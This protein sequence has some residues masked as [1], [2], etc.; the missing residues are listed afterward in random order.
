VLT[1]IESR[2]RD[3]RPSA[4]AG[5]LADNYAAIL[6][7]I[8]TNSSEELRRYDTITRRCLQYVDVLSMDTRVLLGAM[9]REN[10]EAQ[11][12]FVLEC[13]TQD[14]KLSERAE[15][16]LFV[17]KDRDFDSHEIRAELN[18]LSCHCVWDFQ[19]A[20]G[21]IEAELKSQS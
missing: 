2:A 5:R 7:T 15:V 8:L 18:G 6:D 10:L 4:Y 3:A 16:K 14:A 12:A 1:A 21:R 13:I 9:D 20:L 11:D 17:E 19:S